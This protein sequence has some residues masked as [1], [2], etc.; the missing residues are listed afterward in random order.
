LNPR[1]LGYEPYDARLPRPGRSPVAALTS[2]NGCRASAP[3]LGVS[4]VAPHP[5]SSRA[6][7]RAQIWLLTRDIAVRVTASVS[8]LFQGQRQVLQPRSASLWACPRVTVTVFGRPPDRARAPDG[9]AQGLGRPN[10]A[11]ATTIS[12]GLSITRGRC[13]GPLRTSYAPASASRFAGS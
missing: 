6:Q 10:G 9:T 2:A 12:N 1:P 11:S 13:P 7:I 4:R 5:A 3:N 8:G